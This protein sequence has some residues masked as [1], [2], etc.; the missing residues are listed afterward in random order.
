MSISMKTGLFVAIGYMLLLAFII[1][2]TQGIEVPKAMKI[3]FDGSASSFAPA[4]KAMLILPFVAAFVY[5]IL[6]WALRQDNYKILS[7]PVS[8]QSKPK[9]R[10]FMTYLFLS[11]LAIFCS[12]Q[13]LIFFHK[14]PI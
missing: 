12:V 11:V 7:R 5:A 6:N 1:F 3:G 4:Y 10:R 8:E 14:I 9:V 13:T 2:A